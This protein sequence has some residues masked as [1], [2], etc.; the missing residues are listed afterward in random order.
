MMITSLRNIFISLKRN[1]YKAT[2]IIQAKV[3]FMTIVGFN[4][5]KIYVERMGSPKGKINIKNNVG[6]KNVEEADLSLG[7][8]KQSGLRFVFEFTSNYEPKIGEIT[9]TG[10]VLYLAD[11][12]TVK[13]VLKGWKKD[14]KVQKDITAAV[15][16]TV[17]QKSNIQALMLARDI[18][19]PP[20]IPLPK[21]NVADTKEYIG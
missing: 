17:L 2:L 5:T 6:I 7:K 20:P 8:S 1:I 16:N 13:E 15:L 9:L 4:F 18:N 12:K 11:D 3:V 19:L 14:K 10:E 21:V